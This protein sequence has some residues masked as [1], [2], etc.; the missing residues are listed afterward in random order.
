V[1]AIKN[2]K[3][4]LKDNA[5]WKL[6]NPMTSVYGR[7]GSMTSTYEPEVDGSSELGQNDHTYFQE[8]IGML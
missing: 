8:L 3:E 5:K 6:P 1:A 2:V 4:T 7:M